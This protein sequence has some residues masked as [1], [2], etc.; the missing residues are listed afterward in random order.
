MIVSTNGGFHVLVDKNCIKGNP[1]EFAKTLAT[2]LTNVGCE[3]KEVEFKSG[4]CMIP[5]PG[6]LQYGS[7]VVK[8]DE[9]A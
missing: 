8:W 7:Y 3:V 2:L 6:I 1:K 5:C 9:L 4:P